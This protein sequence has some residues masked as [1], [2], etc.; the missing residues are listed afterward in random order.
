[1]ERARKRNQKNRFREVSEW[2]KGKRELVIDKSRL[3]KEWLESFKET[4]GGYAY[5]ALLYA[6]RMK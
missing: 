6:T 1:M 2:L 4:S 5:D 3:P